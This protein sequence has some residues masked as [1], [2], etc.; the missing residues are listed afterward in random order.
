MHTRPLRSL[1]MA[2]SIGTVAA[3]LL[4]GCSNAVAPT[5]TPSASGAV[6]DLLTVGVP[7]PA[8]GINPASVNTAFNDFAGIAYDPLLRLAADGSYAPAL[9][10]SWKVSD[11]NTKMTLELR[12]DVTFS[13]GDK[14]DANAVKASLEYCASDKSVNKQTLQN[15]AS[16]DVTGDYS[17]TVTLSQP[18]PLMEYMLSERQGCGMIISPTGLKNI[19]T[20]TVDSESHGAGP[21]IYQP[22][23]SVTGSKYTYTANPSYY[24]KANFQH[25]KKIVLTVMAQAQAAYNAITTGQIDMTSGDLTTAK[26]AKA[27]GLTVTGTPFVW[28]GLNLI[29]RAGETTP[30][31]GDVRVRQA[32]NYA[33]D[34]KTLATALLGDLGTPTDQ[35]SAE[36]FDGWSQDAADAY[37]FDL[38]KAKQL[39][40]DAGYADGFDLPVV[41]VAFGGQDTLTTALT[42]MLAQIGIRVKATV[43]TDE[44]SYLEGMNNHQNSAASVGY[45]SQPMYLM[46]EALVLPTAAPFNG[47]GTNDPD[48]LA[49]LDKIRTST[50]DDQ[51][52]Y[53]QELNLYLVKNAW[54][55]PVLF[56]PVLY[57]ARAG[58]GGTEVSGERPTFSVV[59][60]YNKD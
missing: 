20:L 51:A 29:D 58:L 12:D 4:S 59:G 60:V 39:M 18:N 48:A 47:F 21:Y 52:K 37:P 1:L 30:A 8:T 41:T 13:D 54:F 44:K 36:G 35:P 46:G 57:Y 31:M 5:T 19:D 16:I 11:G 6:G 33:I 50:A 28:L 38:A 56:T 2:A 42:Q 45:G 14:F 22:S 43:T 25:Y 55:A 49:L 27:A 34:R 24:D 17:L 15:L 40:S 23:Q 32:I 9:A 26:Q 7:A 10:T 53:A 3:L